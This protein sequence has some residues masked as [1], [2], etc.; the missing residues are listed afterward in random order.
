MGDSYLGPTPSG[1][2]RDG[3][4]TAI[5]EGGLGLAA[6]GAGGALFS[7][8]GTKLAERFLA[9]PAQLFAFSIKNYRSDEDR[10]RWEFEI[11]NLSSDGCSIVRATVA[12]PKAKVRLALLKTVPDGLNRTTVRESLRF[13][14]FLAGQSRL[15]CEA[16]SDAPAKVG[17]VLSVEF[18][19]LPL[20]A[21]KPCYRKVHFAWPE[22]F[23]DS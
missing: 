7:G 16:I 17:K 5:V 22:A 6:L 10:L 23:C 19:I 12:N 20:S 21:D 1:K 9:E 13:P 11:A 8:A 3:K 4:K 2:M 15:Q 18:A 14:T